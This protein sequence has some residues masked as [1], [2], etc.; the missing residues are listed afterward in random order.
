M[1]TDSTDKPL[2][3]TP[4]PFRET[5]TD[6][7]A[8]LASI[9][10]WL[11]IS[12]GDEIHHPESNA[13]T[14][15]DWIACDGKEDTTWVVGEPDWL[16][17]GT[18]DVDIIPGRLSRAE[19]VSSSTDSTTSLSDLSCSQD[20]NVSSEQPHDQIAEP[21]CP[22]GALNEPNSLGPETTRGRVRRRNS[23]EELQLPERKRPRLKRCRRFPRM[24]MASD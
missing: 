18:K 10:D 15:E 6:Q 3:R 24:A 17:E 1:A 4:Y 19:S 22:S 9:S 7:S 2:P 16:E 20:T 21:A 14:P 13:L 5:N 11:E 23:G 8:D 12:G